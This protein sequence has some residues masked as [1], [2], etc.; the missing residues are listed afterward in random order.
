MFKVE[1]TIFGEG[2]HGQYEGKRGINDDTKVSHL[3][4]WKDEVACTK[5]R[6][7]VGAAS[8]GTRVWFSFGSEK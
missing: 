6:R 5:M 3:S 8:R 1:L 4:Y 7:V 2:L